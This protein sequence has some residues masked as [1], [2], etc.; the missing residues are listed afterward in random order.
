[1]VQIGGIRGSPRWRG[2]LR[3]SCVLIPPPPGGQNRT[4]TLRA[5]RYSSGLSGDAYV[6]CGE[7]ASALHAT[8]L[9][10]VLQAKALRD[11]H[12]GGHDLEVLKELRTATNLAL[13]AMKVTASSLGRVISTLVVQKHHIWLCLVDIRDADKVRFL[14][15][16]VSQT[17]L[18]GD[19]V[20]NM[21]QQLSA[22]QEQ[23]EA[24]HPAAAPQP[25]RCWGWPPA[26]APTPA[27]H[28]Q[29]PP[30]KQ[31]RGARPRLSRPLSNLA[32]SG[33][34][35]ESFVSK[36]LDKKAVFSVSGSQEGME[37][38]GRTNTGPH[39][40]SSLASRQ[41]WA[42]REHLQRPYSRTLCQQWKQVSV[43]PHTQKP[44]WSAHEPT[45]LGPC[46]PPRCPSAGTAVVPLVPLARYL[47]AWL[48][49]PSPSRWLLRTI[50][51]GYE[52][53]FA[54]HPP[55]FSSIRFTSVK[56][57]D[58]PVLLAEIAVLLATDAIE[59]VPP[60]DM[61]MGFY[62]PYFIVPKKG[63]GLRLILELRVLS[64][65]L[66]QLPFKMLTQK[67]IFGCIRP[68]DW[69]AAIDLKDTYIH[70]SILPY[71]RPFLRFAFEGRAYQYRVLPFRLS[72]SPC[73]FTK[74]AE[75]A[76]VPLREQGVRI[77]NYLDDW[78]ILAQ[79]RDQLCKHR[80]LVVR[81]LIELGLRVNWEKSKHSPTQ[82]ISF[83]GMEL[84]SV[85][86]TARLTKERAWLVLN[87]LN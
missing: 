81:H 21:A 84:D 8:A 40:S 24:I 16:P 27:P 74:V 45:E 49:L 1:M 67:C 71:H 35:G 39:S 13:R 4:S 18:F 61:M 53:Q 82:R 79:S 83:I 36:N 32:V 29:Q 2:Q 43:A 19:A 66:H 9:L 73:V 62:S 46:V 77:L 56:A 41:Q 34:G 5:C 33:P 54:R 50:S 75:G 58:A 6:A 47:G 31:R 23:T 63:G 48:A 7:A 87:C 14:K 37:S 76:L 64:R 15:V 3:C 57:A 26:Y 59:P 28:L 12:E 44:L 38:R 68:R 65:A 70:V 72:L 17:G 11:L 69:F 22:A 78:L 60:A 51:L 55:K 85:E 25:A 86:Q 20:E 42:V 10:Q 80:D 52:I 30:A